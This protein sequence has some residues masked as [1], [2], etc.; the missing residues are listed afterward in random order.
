VEWG[1]SSLYF[2]LSQE[3]IKKSPEFDHTRKITKDYT[4]KLHNHYKG[5]DR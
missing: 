4:D 5:C 1:D 2:N 3:A